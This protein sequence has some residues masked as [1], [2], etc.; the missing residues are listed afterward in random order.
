MELTF[1]YDSCRDPPHSVKYGIVWNFVAETEAQIKQLVHVIELLSSN[2]TMGAKVEQ[3]Q[4]LWI[5]HLFAP[6]LCLSTLMKLMGKSIEVLISCLKINL[7]IFTEQG[8]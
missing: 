8:F 4:S 3:P 2:V 5:N 1:L 7:V 6:L